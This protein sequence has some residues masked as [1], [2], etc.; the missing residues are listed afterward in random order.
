MATN[1]GYDNVNQAVDGNGA[2]GKINKVLG[3]TF[4]GVDT[5]M[6]VK[7]GE[8]VPVALGKALVTN[9][10]F[11]MIPGG[12]IGGVAV[13]GGVAAIQAAPTIA[14]AVADKQARMGQKSMT[15][16]GA[17]KFIGNEGQENM[18]Q[19]GLSQ[20]DQAANHGLKQIMK[21]ARGAHNTY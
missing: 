19:Q 6:R 12:I 15:F 4:V 20:M 13:M 1:Y 8:A 3:P 9:A 16:G 11:S 2:M 5:V 14:R 10:A 17:S 21:H 18:M 7:D